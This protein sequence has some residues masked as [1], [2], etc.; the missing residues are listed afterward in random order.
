MFE[1]RRPKKIKKRRSRL[2]PEEK[3][4]R[5]AR[6]REEKENHRKL[7]I[8]KRD[9]E[10]LAAREKWEQ[11]AAP[12]LAITRSEPFRKWYF[13]ETGFHWPEYCEEEPYDFKNILHAP[14]FGRLL[15]QYSARQG[16]EKY[17]TEYDGS[18][19]DPIIKAWQRRMLR[20]RQATP[21]WVD[22]EKIRALELQRDRLNEVAADGELFHL[23]HVIP[24]QG[25]VVCGLHVH[26]NLQ[27]IPMTENLKKG[28]QFDP[29]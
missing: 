6:R 28:N 19:L 25:A 29:P 15:K 8:A 3:L 20:L 26:T 12:I 16:I 11:Q 7:L 27:V 14:V 22:W 10:R 9:K 5:A 13:N 17:F 23:D 2:T 18:P 1:Y 24:L 4:N 21:K